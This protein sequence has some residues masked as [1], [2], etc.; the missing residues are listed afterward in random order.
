[1]DEGASRLPAAMEL[2]SGRLILQGLCL[3]FTR[4][5]RTKIHHVSG[6]RLCVVQRH[7][8]T[9]FVRIGHVDVQHCIDAAPS[10]EGE[11]SPPC[12]PVDP[13]T[14]MHAY[15]HIVT[16]CCK[17]SS[18]LY[19]YIQPR[20]LYHVLWLQARRLRLTPGF[21]CGVTV[22]R[23]TPTFNT[24]TQFSA[25]RIDS[26]MCYVLS[27]CGFFHGSPSAG[28]DSDAFVFGPCA[29][30]MEAKGTRPFTDRGA[31]LGIG[32]REG[33]LNVSARH[34]HRCRVGSSL[35]WGCWTLAKP[36]VSLL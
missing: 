4:T 23:N 26:G 1:M 16:R 35:T 34:V 32:A 14:S 10:K 15:T 28:P 22:A 17:L 12:L 29:P 20:S 7:L 24:N 6:G 13:R 36:G 5:E 3:S 11:S 31:I 9:E 8:R 18:T 30:A 2:I 19:S 25:L 27:T 21:R 33:R